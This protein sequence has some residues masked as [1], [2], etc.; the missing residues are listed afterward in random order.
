M[1]AELHAAPLE[2][3]D[4][5]HGKVHIDRRPSSVEPVSLSFSC[6]MTSYTVFLLVFRGFTDHRAIML[7]G[8]HLGRRPTRPCRQRACPSAS[9]AQKELECKTAKT[10]AL[11]GTQ[12]NPVVNRADVN[13][14]GKRTPAVWMTTK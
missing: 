8:T 2:S 14:E 12:H 5:Q 10:K 3:A 1:R 11:I 4:V 13:S 6:A 9:K 7:R